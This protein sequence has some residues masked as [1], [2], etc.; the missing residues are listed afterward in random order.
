MEPADVVVV[1]ARA[2]IDERQPEQKCRQR[3]R[4][5]MRRTTIESRQT[6]EAVPTT[7]AAVPAEPRS[8]TISEYASRGNGP[9]G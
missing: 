8:W 9:E 2:R 7:A 1:L 4:S 6:T 5:D 3:R